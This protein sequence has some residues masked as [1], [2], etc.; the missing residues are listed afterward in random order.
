[1]D[2]GMDA[3]MEKNPLTDTLLQSIDSNT[4][5]LLPKF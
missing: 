4:R 1:M 3:G 5:V 2:A